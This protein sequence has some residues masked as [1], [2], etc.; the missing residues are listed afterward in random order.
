MTVKIILLITIFVGMTEVHG[1]NGEDHSKKEKTIEVDEDGFE[2]V[3]S[4]PSEKSLQMIN[5]DYIKN[6][7]EIFSNKCLT[8]H[9]Q[10]PSLPWYY[11]IPGPRQLMDYDM[12]ESKKHMDMSDDFPFAGHG[13]PVDDLTAVERTI[14]K[15]TMPPLRYR[16]LHW[17]S[18]LTK[19][20]VIIIKKW[21]QDSKDVLEEAQ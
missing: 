2:L 19:D 8:C 16:M 6:V 9:G 12:T 5:S 21:V 1:H 11:N 4:G 20:E 17:N 18:K 7:K 13:S 14:K 3:S 10:R 15:G